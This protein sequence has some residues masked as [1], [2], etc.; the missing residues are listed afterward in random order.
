MKRALCLLALAAAAA[1][2]APAQPLQQFAQIGDLK[3][4]SGQTLEN[5]RVGYRTFGRLNREKTNAVL[6]PTWFSGR[7]ED[8][9][10]L[11]GPAGPVD[12]SR[13]YVIAVDALGNGVSCSPSNSVSQPAEQFPHYTIAD[14]VASQ[15]RLLKSLKVPRLHA[16]VGISMGGMQAFQWAVSHPEFVN[17]AVSIVGSPRLTSYDLLLWEAQLRAIETSK[18]CGCPELAARTVAAIHNLALQTPD[19][20]A[21]ET[22]REDFRAYL[23]QIDST[24]DNRYHPENW[25]SQ[26]R[27]MMAHDVGRQPGSLAAAARAVKA[28]MLVVVAEQDHMVNPLP[29]TQFALMTGARLLTLHSNCG[30]LAAGCES[31]RVNQRVNEFLSEGW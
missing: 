2:T 26:L 15:H 10:G 20:R 31:G 18:Q 24:F 8:L 6:F 12:S 3:L 9:Q 19:F 11:I 4:E 16:V 5:C 22:G 17:R 21:E 28:E 7:S 30:H 13:F 23:E 29:A 25:A 27:A 14:M 1:S